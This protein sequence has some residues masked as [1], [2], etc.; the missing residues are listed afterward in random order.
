M[1]RIRVCI[2]LLAAGLFVPATALGHVAASGAQRNAILTAA[3]HQ[4]E[5]SSRQK[6]CLVVT[7]STV[8]KT[9]AAL[10]WPARLTRACAAVAAQGIIVEHGSGKV[11]SVVAA[12][13]SFVCPIKTVPSTVARDLGVCP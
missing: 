3:V 4:G 5:V 9:Y 7:I 11:W 1:I 2:A 12:G 10:S 13:S 8:N 6:T